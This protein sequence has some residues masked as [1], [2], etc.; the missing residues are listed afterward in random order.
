MPTPSL[1]IVPARFKTGT[2]YSQIPIPVAPSTSSVGDFTVTRNTAARRVNSAG[3][4]ES[5]ASGI[6][7]LDYY[8]SGGGAGG[9]CVG[10]GMR[11]MDAD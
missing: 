3:L 2:L 1:L 7:R 4:I 11:G 8:T 6:P 5:V 9:V 10:G